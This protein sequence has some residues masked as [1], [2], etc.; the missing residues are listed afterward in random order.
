MKKFLDKYPIIFSVIVFALSMPIIWG[1]FY[2]LFYQLP[3]YW[4]SALKYTST[5]FVVVVICFVVYRKIPFTLQCKGLFKGLFTFGSVGLICAVMA[6]L[7]SYNTPD[8]TPSVFTVLG[9]IFYNLGIAVSEEFLFRGI[10]FTQML[11][12]RKNK[13]GFIWAAVIVSSVIFGLRHFLNLVTTPNIVISTVGQVLF[14]F[15]AGVYLCAVYLR[16]RN[17]WVCIM[18]HFLEDFFTGFWAMVSTSAAAAQTTDGTITNMILLVAVHSVYIIFGIIMLKS[19][20]WNYQPLK[21]KKDR[22][23]VL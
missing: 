3:F 5:L 7:F 21:E 23:M 9:F 1:A 17:I 11:E 16:T 6:F 12:S 19:K 2:P 10:I 13:T 20:K 14:T 18:I 22:E 15:M 4:A 8:I